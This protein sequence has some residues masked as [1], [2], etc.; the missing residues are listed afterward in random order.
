MIKLIIEN[1]L[2]NTTQQM[3]LY[4]TLC[5]AGAA[6]AVK[7]AESAKELEVSETQLGQKDA[8]LELAQLAQSELSD[9]TLYY[10]D[11]ELAQ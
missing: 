8:L 6:A 1:N 4:A 7:L 3:K 5:L 11:D 2:N 9:L 10:S